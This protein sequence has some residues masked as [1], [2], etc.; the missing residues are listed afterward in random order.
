MKNKI[1]LN[2]M[3]N[4]DK[5][6]LKIFI[7]KS[8]GI[9]GK[10]IKKI[11]N[12]DKYKNIKNYLD[13]RYKDSFSYKETIFRIKNHID[14]HPLCDTCHKKY[15]IFIGGINGFSKC[16]C[17]SCSAK[18]KETIQ[19]RK[20]T[21]LI[22]YGDENFNNRDKCRLTSLN[23]YGVDNPAKAESVKEKYKNLMQEK[24]G[25]DNAWQAKEVKDKI[26]N[27]CL[28]KYG[29]ESHNSSDIVKEHK[30][31]HFQEKYGVNSSF[32]IP[33]VKE[34]IKETIKRKYG[35]DS[36]LK[37]D[38]CILRAKEE[39]LKKYGVEYMF[40]LEN[41]CD[42][43]NTREKELETKRKNK[44]FTFSKEENTLY[45]YIKKKFPNVKQQYNEDKR[46]PF[47]CDFYIPELDYFIEYNGFICHGRHPFDNTNESDIKI[48]KEWQLKY[49]NGEHP[50]YGH[51]IDG[52]TKRDP[53][54][55]KYA[56]ENNLNFKEVWSLKEGKEFID[57]LYEKIK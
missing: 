54:K 19:K 27:T 23:K 1:Y 50:L 20:N 10:R 24:Y 32:Q 33:E 11:I 40:Q 25:V 17:A 15:V 46:Y 45:L 43:Y 53:Y 5:L 13:T 36:S 26:K 22:K 31:N 35:V 57:K 29:V 41:Y 51:M 49:N 37:M 4:H 14:I 56:I 16:C 55:R 48:L 28:I 18:N 38:K 21:R 39:R 47:R 3:E 42:I 30:R 6:I 8:N 52:W 34:K 2:K 12:N 7:S 9:N 44:S